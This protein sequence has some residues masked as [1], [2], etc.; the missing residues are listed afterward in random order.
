MAKIFL[1]GL[2]GS[3]LAFALLAPNAASAQASPAST[4]AGQGAQLEDIVVTAQRRSEA[5]QSVPIAISAFSN[6]RLK[7]SGITE[8]SGLQTLVPGLDFGRT[9]NSG[10]PRLRGIGSSNAA[11]GDESPIAIYVDDVYR[12]S[13]V[14]NLIGLNNVERIEVLKGPQGTLFGR[15]ASGGVI[16][17][18]TR[19]PSTTPS[20]DMSVGYA[21]YDT[22]TADF[23]GTTG[24]TDNLAID[25]AVGYRDQ[26]DGWG[27]NLTTGKDALFTDD[28]SIRSK[29][30]LDLDRTQVTL[31]GDYNRHNTDVGSAVRSYPGARLIDGQTSTDG[32][33]DVRQNYS[34]SG[35]ARQGGVSLKVNHEF[36]W[37]N[38][39]SITA[40]R[41]TTNVIRYDQDGTPINVIAFLGPQYDKAFSQELQLQS[42]SD[43]A[44]SW[45]L[46]GFYFHDK[47]A[48]NPLDVT[49]SGIAPA[50]RR[51][52]FNRATTNSYSAFAQA[53]GDIFADT[54]LTLGARYTVDKRRINNQAI[55]TLATGPVVG[56]EVTDHVRFPK[57]TWRASLDHKLSRDVLVYGS[58]SRGF[59]SGVYDLVSGQPRP[60]RPEVVDAYEIG[61]KS[62]LLNRRLRVNLSAFL[63]D[64]DDLQTNAFVDGLG[65]ILLNAG[66]ARTKGFDFELEALA[67]DA[68]RLRANASY[69]HAKFVSYPGAPFY[70]PRPAP[71]GGNITLPPEDSDASGNRIPRSPKFTFSIGGD[72]TLETSAGKFIL[73]AN[74]FHNDGYY[75]DPQNRL[76]QPS[77]TLVNASLTWRSND[78]TWDVKVW[79]SN[80]L[81]EKYYANASFSGL[82]DFVSPAEPLTFGVTFGAHF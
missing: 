35:R 21:N 82:G 64:I 62:D 39:V 42:P 15:N 77:F 3:A 74:V 8:S 30:F 1:R 76:T 23:Y 16:H 53:S 38:I 50:L 40:W 9:V 68:L 79:G 36:D 45:I 28:F 56:P 18:I 13:T 81:D 71:G 65:Q 32:F 17:I 63:N 54:K 66:K 31:A 59:K 7:A 12:P 61:L 43:S 57:M 46:G 49:G 44:I 19:T 34:S 33:Y 47:A 5:V 58:I 20:V 69:L 14:G 60:I 73:D 55:T 70:T 37:A 78:E 52:A 10:L 67:T 25:L 26:G 2:S 29:L 27:K 75:W 22:V 24:I 51:Q 6:E 80:L 11:P 48:Y 72:Y 4:E 41:K